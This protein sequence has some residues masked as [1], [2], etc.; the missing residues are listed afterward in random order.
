MASSQRGWNPDVP[1]EPAAIPMASASIARFRD[2]LEPPEWEQFRRTMAEGASLLQKRRLWNIN[3]TAHGGGVAEML[4]WQIPYERDAG[5]DVRWLVFQGDPEFFAFTKRLHALLHGISADGSEISAAERACYEQTAA[6]NAAALD[7]L[8]DAGDL[9]S[10]HDPQPAGLIPALVRRGCRVIWRCHIGVDAPNTLS[11]GA[12]DFLRPWIGSSHAYVFSRRAYVWD[13]LDAS[14]VAIIPPAIDAFS[15]KNAEMRPETAAAV[16]QATGIVQAGGDSEPAFRARDGSPRKV[17]RRAQLLPDA[18]LPVDAPFV[19]QVSRWDRLKD[20]VGVLKGFAMIVDAVGAGHLVLAGPGTSSV[21]DDP[22]EKAVLREVE[23]AW[24]GLPARGQGRIHLVRLPMEDQDENAAI[25]NALQRRA[26]VVVQKS[27]REGF[28]LTVAEAM[29]KSRPVVASR[30]G[31]IQDQI[32]NGKNGVLIDDPQDLAA[33]GTAVARLF[34]DRSV[35]ERLGAAAK[36]RV[37]Q[38]FLA[39]RLLMQHVQL[40]RKL[41]RSAD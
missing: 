4:A 23:D 5:M 36:R 7:R 24:R 27:L 14:R 6:A 37:Q 18:K 38:E 35:A 8:I 25:V 21:A 16:L 2:L 28:G 17:E 19:L 1:P 15:P 31:G 40:A 33:F 30:V 41:L 29:W 32:E 13:G 22:E 39:P 34:S 9:V 12:W 11:K 3:S 10:V 26:E 20:P